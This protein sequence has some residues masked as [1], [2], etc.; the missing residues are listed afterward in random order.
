MDS[1]RVIFVM[2]T[3]ISPD[4][5]EKYNEW[6]DNTHLAMVLKC[7]GMLQARR[8][9]IVK[10]SPNCPKYITIYDLA[11][12]ASIDASNS[13]AEMSAVREDKTRPF[14][15]DDISVKWRAHYKLIT[16]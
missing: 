3:D 4:K 8:Y 7:P 6:Y 12:E 14:T 11:N 1:N 15:S 10:Q 16:P 13:S 9:Q 5:E 2:G